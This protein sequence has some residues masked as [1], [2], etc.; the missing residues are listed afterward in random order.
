M[1]LRTIAL[2]VLLT[3]GASSS[4]FSQCQGNPPAGR[5]CGNGTAAAGLPSWYTMSIMLDRNFG[6]PSAQGTML[7]RG[8]SLWSATA[9]PTLGLNGTAGGSLT[10]EGA[11]SGAAVIG[12]KAAASTTT[13]NLPVGNGTINQVLITDGSGNTS[14]ATAGSGTVSSVGLALPSTILTVSGSPVTGAGTLTGT[15]A[16]QT[17][18]TVWA[19]PTTGSAATPTFR[20]LVGADLP[21]PTSGTL[22]GVESLAAVTSNWIRAISTSGVP[23]ASQPAFTDISGSVAAAQLPNPTAST[24]GGIESYVAVA[25]QWINTISTSGVPSSTQ[26]AFTDISGQTT[27]AQLPSIG[28]NSILSNIT[29]GTTTPLANSLTAI[30]DSA[31]DNTQGDILYR[32]GTVWTALNPGTSGQVLTT[33]GAS[34]N[35]SWTTVTGTGTVT[36]VATNNGLTGGTITTTGTIGLATIATGNVLANT[37]GGSAV[38]TANTPTKVLDV[39]GATEGDILYRGASVWTA[40]APGTNGQF[41]QTTGA[42]STPQWAT[43]VSSLNTL[44]GALTLLSGSQGRLTLT[45]HTPIMSASVAGGTTIYYDSFIGNQVAYFNGSNDVMDTIASNEVSDA[46]VSAASAGQVVAGN[47]YDIWWVHGGANRICIAM[48]AST[49]GG[50]GW[51]SDTGGSNTARGTG[52]SQIDQ[53]TRPY[54]TNKNSITNCFNGATNYGPVSANQ[55]TYLGTIES[56]GNGQVSYV[57]GAPAS[58]GSA[59]LFGIWNLNTV[60][61]TSTVTDNGSFYT[62]SSATVREARGSTGNQIQFVIGLPGYGLTTSYSGEA[63]TITFGASA[64]FGLGFDQTTAYNCQSNG[65]HTPTSTG[66]VVTAFRSTA[67][68]LCSWNPGVGFHTLS[69]NENSDS[70][71][72][73]QFDNSGTDSLN[74]SLSN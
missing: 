31:I 67:S 50:G 44:T 26:P 6:A 40:L 11:T 62:Y 56:S 29:G 28:S 36:S 7:N 19:G 35:P 51:G 72:L 64:T 71:N 21:N 48:S 54:P 69:A 49:G 32:S 20:S 74:I 60:T 53:T 15:L 66:N 57:F 39:I 45:S 34:A 25:H 73:N 52:Y 58:G 4:A 70:S 65:I 38:P 12:V 14:W 13:F 16:T 23:S 46:M 43:S 8:A 59:G 37:S 24:L 55:G 42:G 63:A 47:V 27:L 2:A 9:T 30:I 1:R 68:T 3:V 41:L 17:Q 22:G 5:I 10:L 33:A 61:T 18:N